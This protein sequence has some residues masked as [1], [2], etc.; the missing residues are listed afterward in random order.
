MDR[1]VEQPDF[2]G[3]KD[4]QNFQSFP[5][6]DLVVAAGEER[7][8]AVVERTELADAAYHIEAAVDHT[9]YVVVAAAAAAVDYTSSV[10]AV[11]VGQEVLL[12][13]RVNQQIRLT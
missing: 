11:A 6:W 10:A 7:T 1:W 3:T 8:V 9:S 2:V 5:S 12:L 4:N 13:H